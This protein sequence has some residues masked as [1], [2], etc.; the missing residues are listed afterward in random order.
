MV[1]TRHDLVVKLRI[2][3]PP[4]AHC[5]IRSTTFSEGGV[6]EVKPI[7]VDNRKIAQ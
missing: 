2:Q 4:E 7:T 6:R 3:E 5:A 1:R